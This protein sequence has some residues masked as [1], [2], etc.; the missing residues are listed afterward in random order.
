MSVTEKIEY[1]FDYRFKWKNILGA[2]F[3]GSVL[4]VYET[5]VALTNTQR[6]IINGVIE[7][8]VQQATVFYWISAVVMFGLMLLSIFSLIQNLFG[9][10]RIVLSRNGLWLPGSMWSLREKFYEFSSIKSM[11]IVSI[12]RSDVLQVTTSNSSFAIACENLSSS[13]EFERVVSLMQQRVSY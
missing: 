4:G 9:T 1:S 3:I 2:F 11:R 10:K 7:L 6:L 8:S 13:D 5:H 12:Y